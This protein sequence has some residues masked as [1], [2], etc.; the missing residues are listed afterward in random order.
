VRSLRRLLREKY[1]EGYR[2]L[3]H[4]EAPNADETAGNIARLIG[5]HIVGHP[6]SEHAH[7]T[8]VDERYPARPPLDR[9]QDIVDE[10]QELI[11]TP[12]S[13]RELRRS[14]EWATVRRARKAGRPITI[15]WP[16]GCTNSDSSHEPHDTVSYPREV[17]T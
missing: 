9:D 10:T 8:E 3:D 5:Y 6:S 13:Y 15:I 4:G 17:K 7:R 12:A 1:L 2:Y 11:A 14:G 16:D